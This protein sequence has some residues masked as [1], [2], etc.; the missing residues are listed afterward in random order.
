MEGKEGFK[1]ECKEQ[2]LAWIR[3]GRGAKGHRSRPYDV[4]NGGFTL[5]R[6][7][8]YLMYS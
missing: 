1:G 5:V 3:Q 6:Y 4:E 2:G 7:L 8:R